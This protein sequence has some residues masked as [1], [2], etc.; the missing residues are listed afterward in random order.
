MP[1]WAWVLTCIGCAL[2]GCFLGVLI[3]ALAV[4]AGEAS[5]REEARHP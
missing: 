4:A 1:V 2:A 5:R 3:T